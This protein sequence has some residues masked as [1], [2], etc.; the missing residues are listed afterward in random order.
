[1]AALRSGEMEDSRALGSTCVPTLLRSGAR[2]F[3]Q[4]GPHRRGHAGPKLRKSQLPPGGRL[5][6]RFGW[7]SSSNPDS[8]VYAQIM[9]HCQFNR[10]LNRHQGSQGVRSSPCSSQF[11][12]MAYIQLTGRTSL[13]EI[14]TCPNS[15]S[16]RLY[17]MAF[18]SAT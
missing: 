4:D 14:E 13:R 10:C 16:E 11:M 9:Q 3:M 12:C 1:M 17:H 2:I 6:P 5:A 7:R 18:R 15:E 8:T